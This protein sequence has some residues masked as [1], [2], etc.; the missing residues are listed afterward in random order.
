M[1]MKT[2]LVLASTSLTALFLS[3][4]RADEP[5]RKAAETPS[6]NPKVLEFLKPME[7]G[8]DDNELTKKLKER[9][10]CAVT[11]LDER[12]KE[13]R[14]GTRDLSSVFDAAR[15]TLEAKLDLAADAEARIKVLGLGLDVAKLVEEQLQQQVARG[16]GSKAD[17]ERARY[18]RLSLEVELLRAKQKTAP[19]P[20]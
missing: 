17:L 16:F 5:A 3:L 11:M 9:H 19:K 14:K 13:Y 8:K 6:V 1:S 7:V 10:N 4:A 12:V 2:A 15:T 20:D 18:G